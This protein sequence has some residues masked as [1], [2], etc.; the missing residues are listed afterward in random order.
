MK[1]P[2]LFAA[3]FACV[4]ATQCASADNWP[5]FRGPTGQGISS[6]KGVP[7]TWSATA[8][9]RW[10][11]PVPGEGWS[12]PV[13][14]GGRVFLTTATDNGASCR[15]LCYQA[16]TGTLLWNREVFRQAPGQRNPRNSYAT[17]TPATDGR[18]VYAQFWDGSVAA[19]G[20]NGVVVWVNRDH[21]FH[22]EHGLASSPILH[23]GLVIMA[24]D[25]SSKGP[26]R[27]VG[28]QTPWD[29]ARL[30]ALDAATGKLRW[31][32]TRGMSRIAHS[33]PVVASDGKGAAQVV[34]VAGDV[35]QGFDPGTGERLWSSTNKCE[36]LVPSPAV[37]GGL[38]FTA[39][40]FGGAEATRAYRLGGRGDLGETNL[41]WSQPRGTPKVPSFLY[42]AP[43]L[44]SVSDTGL[45]VCMEAATGRVVWEQRLSGGFSAS[46]VYA[47]GRVYFLSDQGETTVVEAGPTPKIASRNQLGERCQASI[48]VSNG[49]IF[50]RTE[51]N[52]FCIGR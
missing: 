15:V 52:L 36:G 16:D 33:A 28:W 11:A 37:G 35:V 21:P 7:V 42:V 3:V 51:A 27:S 38:V 5:Q 46:P 34:S 49:R 1:H 30:L 17:P 26:D 10:R 20:F 41:V 29:Q 13:V 8:G 22:S 43:H 18:R 47:D 48:A 23:G 14:W 50:I 4:A 6:E 44:Y 19:V 2:R 12:S 32:G 45:A 24:R 9:V 40:G 31:A 39:S 25:G